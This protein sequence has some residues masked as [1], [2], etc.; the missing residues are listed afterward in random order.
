MD[1]GETFHH[2]RI[3]LSGGKT[4]VADE[5]LST[6]VL[7]ALQAKLPVHTTKRSPFPYAFACP[8]GVMR[9]GVINSGCTEIMSPWGDAVAETQ[10]G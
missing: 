10:V 8:A 2:P 7:S 3:D 5:T 4:I 1:I 9:K 6:E